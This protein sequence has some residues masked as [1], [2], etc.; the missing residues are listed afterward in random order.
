VEV[1]FHEFDFRCCWLIGILLLTR[2]IPTPILGH[3][4]KFYG[5]TPSHFTRPAELP[6]PACLLMFPS[7]R[8]SSLFTS[9][10][11]DKILGLLDIG[12]KNGRET[13][14][15]EETRKCQVS[16]STKSLGSIHV[17][18]VSMRLALSFSVRIIY[19]SCIWQDVVWATVRTQWEREMVCPGQHRL[20]WLYKQQCKIDVR[21]HVL[22]I[23][24]FIGS[25][26]RKQ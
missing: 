10:L 11:I 19:T 3:G 25:V 12:Q 21:A 4:W 1:Q 13:Q 15:Q 17:A 14:Q 6:I 20:E 16:L 26:R 8:L 9:M 22:S 2:E 7:S 18:S 24:C 5:S 23:I